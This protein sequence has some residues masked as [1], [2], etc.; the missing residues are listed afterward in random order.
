VDPTFISALAP[1]TE[2]RIGITRIFPQAEI[3]P[4][5]PQ[6]GFAQ[7][8]A[9]D[10]KDYIQASDQWGPLIVIMEYRVKG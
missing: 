4:L 9:V 10:P 1:A 7:L 6:A 8:P 2:S 3:I 5:G